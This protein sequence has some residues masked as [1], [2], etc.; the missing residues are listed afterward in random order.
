M[1]IISVQ[2]LKTLIDNNPDIQLIDVREPAEHAEFNFGGINY[3]LGRINSFDTEAIEHLMDKEIYL[4]CRS[5]NRSMQAC[6]LL[7]QA[8]FQHV[9]NVEGGINAWKQ[10]L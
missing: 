7:Q 1:N 9:N 4:Y 8:G 10:L 6:M 2:E 5:G 3:P